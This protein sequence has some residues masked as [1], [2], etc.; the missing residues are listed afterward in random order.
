MLLVYSLSKLDTLDNMI[1]DCHVTELIVNVSA[2][3]VSA[4]TNSHVPGHVNQ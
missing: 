4:A 1:C 3:N 2:V